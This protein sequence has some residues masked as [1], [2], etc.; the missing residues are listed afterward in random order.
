MDFK[1]DSFVY[2]FENS[3]FKRWEKNFEMQ[4]GELT[5]IILELDSTFCEA[6]ECIQHLNQSQATYGSHISTKIIV[7]YAYIT[8]F[9]HDNDFQFYKSV[10]IFLFNL[11]ICFPFFC[12]IQFQ[13]HFL[14][15]NILKDITIEHESYKRRC[16]E[17]QINYN[18]ASKNISVCGDCHLKSSKI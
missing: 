1:F 7:K 16:S 9:V 10:F 3:S 17:E 11:R 12:C 15:Q 2:I 13:F 14:S 4:I 8:L 6:R 5:S 18:I